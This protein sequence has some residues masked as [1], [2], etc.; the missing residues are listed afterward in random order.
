[1]D[2]LEAVFH[3][4]S[5][6]N[7]FLEGLAR[8][9]ERY[10]RCNV[11]KGIGDNLKELLGKRPSYGITAHQRVLACYALRSLGAEVIINKTEELA[12]R[13]EGTWK[14]IGRPVDVM[15]TLEA[16]AMIKLNATKDKW[17]DLFFQLK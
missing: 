9:R 14:D 1:M 12:A 4:L 5:F 6:D 16:L 15:P 17:D 7:L 11:V 8:P 10:G 2:N 3:Y 13:L